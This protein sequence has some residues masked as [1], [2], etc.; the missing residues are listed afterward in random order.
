MPGEGVQHQGDEPRRAR[1]PSQESECSASAWQTLAADRPDLDLLGH[2]LQ[3][4]HRPLH[5]RPQ[6]RRLQRLGMGLLAGPQV[7]NPYEVGIISGFADEIQ[8]A[9]WIVGRSR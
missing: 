4:R 1:S 6:L 9:G 2:A 3:E 5:E 7:D 8:Q